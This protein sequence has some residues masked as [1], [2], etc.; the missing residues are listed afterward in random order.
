M[1]AQPY[2]YSSG[3]G[4]TATRWAPVQSVDR[5]QGVGEKEERVEATPRTQ[6]ERAAHYTKEARLPMPPRPVQ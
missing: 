5:G 1:H 4:S 6:S 3:T 2:E